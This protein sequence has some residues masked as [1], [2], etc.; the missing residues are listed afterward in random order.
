MNVEAII[1]VFSDMQEGRQALVLAKFA[2]E[3]TVLTRETYLGSTSGTTTIKGREINELQHRVIAAIVTRLTSNPQRYPDD[4]LVR[5]C[6][7]PANNPLA[8]SSG[9]IFARLVTEVASGSSVQ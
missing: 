3:L 2:Y 6:I 9:P 5:M 7:D 8:L 4:V 1:K